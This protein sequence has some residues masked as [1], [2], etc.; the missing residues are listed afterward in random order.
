MVV[1]GLERATVDLLRTFLGGQQPG[2]FSISTG[3]LAEF[4]LN[5]LLD[6]KLYDSCPYVVSANGL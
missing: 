2:P 1:G 5:A 6:V 3:D 4:T